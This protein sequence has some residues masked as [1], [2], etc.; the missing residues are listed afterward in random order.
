[1]SLFFLASQAVGGG[2]ESRILLQNKAAERLIFE[3]FCRFSF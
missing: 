3:R 2:F 1:M